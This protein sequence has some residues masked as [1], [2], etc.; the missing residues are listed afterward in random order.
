MNPSLKRQLL[1]T[2][3][4]MIDDLKNPKEI[5][6]FLTDFFDNNELEKYIRRLATAYWLKKGRSKEN[7]RT[8]L[9]ASALDLKE[10]EKLLKTEGGKLALKKI[11]AEEWANQWAERIKKVVK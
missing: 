11:E 2:F 10:A 3:V 4:Q 7:I 1:R 9:K 6:I 8:N 5:E